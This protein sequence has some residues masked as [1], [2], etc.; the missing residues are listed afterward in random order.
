MDESG[1][2][3]MIGPDILEDFSN[4]YD[5]VIAYEERLNKN[6]GTSIYPH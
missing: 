2:R 6:I 1:G 4:L 3:E 5:S